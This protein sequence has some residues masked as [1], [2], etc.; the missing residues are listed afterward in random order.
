MKTIKQILLLC[1]LWT[2]GISASA[3]D[4][5]VDGIYYNITSSTSPYTVAVTYKTN[6]Y[7][8]YSG[9]VIIPSSVTYNSIT[10][11]VTSIGYK[12]FSSCS[13]LTSITIPN[14]VTSIG[15]EAFSY[16]KGLTRV[17]ITDL[18]AWCNISFNDYNGNPCYYAHH[19]YLNDE[20]ITDL[21]IPNSV[22]SIG[23]NAFRG[24]SGLTS[25]TCKFRPSGTAHF[26]VT[27]PLISAVGFFI[28]L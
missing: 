2:V 25:V 7:K 20:E 24:C 27:V 4:F 8:S 5:Y 11:S 3:Y 13:G 21:V 28:S 16:C 17:N 18:E 1:L 14:S 12:A 22:T 15:Y 19:L 6:G 26:G 10:Y 23:N 9:D